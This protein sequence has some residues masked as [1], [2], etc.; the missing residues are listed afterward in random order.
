MSNTSE[1]LS[2]ID[3]HTWFDFAATG[4]D[5]ELEQLRHFVGKQDS[6]G[7]TALMHY[8]KNGWYKRIYLFIDELHLRDI[9]GD[10][11]LVYAKRVSNEEAV[12][13]INMILKGNRNQRSK[14]M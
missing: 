2:N 7:R 6:H 14:Q 13:Y 12:H 10:D 9:N 8:V 3:L 4:N 1:S 11:A 5:W